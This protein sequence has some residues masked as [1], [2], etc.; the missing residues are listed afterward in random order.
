M[1]NSD[2]KISATPGKY[3]GQSIYQELFL[4]PNIGDKGFCQINC[5][6]IGGKYGGSSIRVSEKGPIIQ[7]ESF[8]YALRVSDEL[9]SQIKDWTKSAKMM[10]TDW[11]N[12]IKL[13][14]I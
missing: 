7:F 1:S 13:L 9:P 4:L 3:N 14:L 2:E 8:L 11:R 5:F 10:K 6:A 12:L